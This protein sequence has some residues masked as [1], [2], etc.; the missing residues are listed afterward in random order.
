MQRDVICVFLNCHLFFFLQTADFIEEECDFLE[1]VIL[2]MM[3]CTLM[4]TITLV[5]INEHTFGSG[6][7]ISPC[8][9]TH[10]YPKLPE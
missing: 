1:G 2:K 4:V 3:F 5:L 7:V 10:T 8:L 6:M 9:Q